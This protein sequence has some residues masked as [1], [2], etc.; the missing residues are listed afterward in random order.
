M[1]SRLAIALAL[2]VLSACTTI[3]RRHPVAGWPELKVV[4]HY[5]DD[6]DMRRRCSRYV[7]FGMAPNACAEFDFARGE[8]HVWYS[9]EYPPLP[10]V[11]RHER[12]H[13]QGYEHP[14]EDTLA[15]ALARYRAK[16]SN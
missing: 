10:G 6:G 15:R 2:I 8:C 12:L 1:S 4:E 13:C 9:E 7:A 5:V 11:I 3:D 16:V 14:G